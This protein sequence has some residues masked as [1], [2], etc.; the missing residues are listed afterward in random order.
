MRSVG[1][2]MLPHSLG[3]TRVNACT[4]EVCQVENTS[5]QTEGQCDHEQT[6]N[7]QEERCM[8]VFFSSAEDHRDSIFRIATKLL[9]PC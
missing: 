5:S 1:I 3:N 4:R 9:K 8:F 6:T 2:H 7:D